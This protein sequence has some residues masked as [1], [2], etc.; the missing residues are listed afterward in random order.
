MMTLLNW[1]SDSN[2]LLFSTLF[3]TPEGWLSA[4]SLWIYDITSG[5]LEQLA[6][7]GEDDQVDEMGVWSP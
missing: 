4:D 3:E 2:R 1:S 7:G 6:T 5:A